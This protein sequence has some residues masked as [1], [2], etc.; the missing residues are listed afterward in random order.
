MNKCEA[1]KSKKAKPKVKKAKV[2]KPKPKSKKS[3]T[4][5]DVNQPVLATKH[6]KTKVHIDMAKLHKEFGSQF[7]KLLPKK[8]SMQKQIGKGAF[9]KVYLSCNHKNSCFVLKLQVVTDKKEFTDELKLQKLFHSKKLA[10]KLYSYKLYTYKNKTI[11]AILM[12]PVDYML[13]T[14]LTNKLPTPE[15]NQYIIWLVEVIDLLCKYKLAHNDLHFDNIAISDN[16]G[17]LSPILIDFGQSTVGKCYPQLEF[18]QM[19]RTL[20]TRYFP[21]L[22]K[23][24]IKYLSKELSNIYRKRFDSKFK[25]PNTTK[26][27]PW[28]EKLHDKHWKQAMDENS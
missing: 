12:D 10:P 24:N 27:V 20:N 2:K 8:H 14:L 21:E 5:Y 26:E 13:P 15:L 4:F 1:K 16:N 6:H 11:G 7:L 23:H 22:H 18:L 19:I 28:L 17:I 9:G 3:Q 25:T